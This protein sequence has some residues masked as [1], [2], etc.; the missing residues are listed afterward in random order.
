MSTSHAAFNL[1]ALLLLAGNKTIDS[2]IDLLIQFIDE[3]CEETD[4]EPKKQ[5]ELLSQLKEEEKEKRL[6]ESI[7]LIQKNEPQDSKEALIE[8]A[9][10]LLSINTVLPESS[11]KILSHIAGKWGVDL[12]KL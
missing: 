3:T 9:L 6:N 10:G 11:K 5:I 7:D 12:N 4:F 8:Y 2:R 1:L